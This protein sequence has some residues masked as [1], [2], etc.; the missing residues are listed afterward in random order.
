MLLDVYTLFYKK[1]DKVG[2]RISLGPS[3]KYVYALNL[4]GPLPRV[5][6]GLN[7]HGPRQVPSALGKKS[8]ET[9]FEMKHEQ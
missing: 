3:I 6:V 8:L 9:M 7:P 4:G 2:R 5:P 1:L